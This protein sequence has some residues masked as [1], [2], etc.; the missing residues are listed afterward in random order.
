MAKDT[1]RDSLTALTQDG[2]IRVAKIE[3]GEPYYEITESGSKQAEHIIADAFG[4]PLQDFLA[5]PLSIRK[6][7]HQIAIALLDED[8]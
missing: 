7:I 3:N 1:L 6:R 4:V 5:S 2:D 8:D